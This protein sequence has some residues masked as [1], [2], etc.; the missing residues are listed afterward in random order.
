MR[1]I[2]TADTGPA[3]K[4][5]TSRGLR[6]GSRELFRRLG[7]EARKASARQFATGAGWEPARDG[8]R[9]LVETGTLRE[10]LTR[11][12]ARFQRVGITADSVEIETTVP[13]AQ[14]L[15]RGARGAPPRDPSKVDERS[16]QR[17][18]TAVLMAFLLED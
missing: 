18:A 1:L 12:G 3:V 9:P 10:S 17:A 11:A 6:L 8:G 13:Y 15:R 16:L 14:Y 5:L 4:E 7:D 2:V